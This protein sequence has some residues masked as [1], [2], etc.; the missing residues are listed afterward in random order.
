[1]SLTAILHGAKSTLFLKDNGWISG[2]A[3][4]PF[5]T[6]V[7]KSGVRGCSGWFEVRLVGFSIHGFFE[8]LLR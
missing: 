1:M 3:S 5:L 2:R 7:L 4:D 6:Q 8:S